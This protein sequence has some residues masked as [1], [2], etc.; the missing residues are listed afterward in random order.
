LCQLLLR[1]DEQGL[2]ISRL[3]PAL[4]GPSIAETLWPLL[5][6]VWREKAVSS[7][8]DRQAPLLSSGEAQDS[9]K[10]AKQCLQALSRLERSDFLC[11]S[12]LCGTAGKWKAWCSGTSVCL[13]RAHLRSLQWSVFGWRSGGTSSARTPSG[14]SSLY[15]RRRTVLGQSWSPITEW[16]LNALLTLKLCPD[17]TGTPVSPQFLTE[18]FP[19]H[20]V[21]RD[22][23][24]RTL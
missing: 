10:Q 18:N 23:C 21:T 2:E 13:P 9:W 6:L 24:F 4:L 11:V 15:S 1:L 12:E 8:V 22:P 17:M 14:P 7:S 5:L 16:G 19:R 3:W 20:C